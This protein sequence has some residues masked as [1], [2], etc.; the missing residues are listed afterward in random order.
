MRE[1]ARAQ[2]KRSPI[3]TLVLLVAL[4]FGGLPLGARSEAETAAPPEAGTLPEPLR[5]ALRAAD[6]PGSA[7]SIVVRP[8]DGG[9]LQL[10]FNENVARNPA[11]TMKLVTTYAALE[12]LGP[13]FRWRTEA[14]AVGPLRGAT[15]AGD[16]VIRGSGDPK[17][18]VEQLWLLV[19]QIRAFGLRE[20][21]GDLLLDRSAFAPLVHDPALFD[22]EPLRAYNTG[23]DALLLNFKTVSFGFVPDPETRSVRVLVAPA[24]A[25]LAAPAFVRAVDGPCGDWRARLRADFD[26]PLR[27]RFRGSFPLSC[28][29]QTWHVSVLE[30]SAYFAAVFRSLWEGSG[31]TWR[32]R[33]REAVVPAGA[34]RIA[35]HE[36][37]PLADVIRDINKY[38]NNVMARQLFLALGTAGGSLP[39]SLEGAA[40]A[41]VEWLFRRGIAMPAL[42]L[43]N[44]S[45]LSR[46]EYVSA[47]GLARL[48]E[49]AF[50]G[51]LMPEFV[52][53]LPLVGVDG[54]ARST[55][56][57]AAGRAHIKSGVL[58][59]VRSE[60]GYVRSAGGRRYAVVVLVNGP[61][62]NEAQPLLDRVLDW[63]FLEG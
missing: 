47:D 36:S 21:R 16:L 3:H 20:I 58:T 12:L 31:G 46:S 50:A 15:L 8:V 13:A 43:A 33:V 49:V 38:S 41:V 1:A 7:V 61:K 56:V 60:A 5:D 59:D 62:A 48:L 19:Q 27:P 53:S 63:V 40:G 22:G 28:G 23:P 57:L 26:D 11:S 29:E 2:G 9:A 55:A 37:P 51:P 45:G 6:I 10:A 52:S 34:R 30:H 24:L 17:L 4:C 39:G 18:V 42:V 35:V 54:T 44:G 14:F 32:G 25:G